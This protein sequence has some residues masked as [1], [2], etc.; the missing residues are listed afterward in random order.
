MTEQR[1]VRLSLGTALI[2]AI[3]LTPLWAIRTELSRIRTIQEIEI[4]VRAVEVGVDPASLPKG[5]HIKP[6]AGQ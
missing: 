2:L 5:C 6:K 4:C 3:I 1:E